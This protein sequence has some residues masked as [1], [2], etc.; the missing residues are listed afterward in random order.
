VSGILF[1]RE[2]PGLPTENPSP[3]APLADR[4]RPRSLDEVEG[5][6]EVVGSNGFLSRAIS[7]DRVP[8]LVF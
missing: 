7:E 3:S 4:M 5:P 2:E 1:D 8:S 6:P